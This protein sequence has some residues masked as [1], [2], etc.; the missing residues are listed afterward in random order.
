MK[1]LEKRFL[2]FL[3]M[4]LITHKNEITSI[5]DVKNMEQEFIKTFGT[6]ENHY[7]SYKK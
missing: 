7:K 6:E 3:S 2:E 4:Y 5:D 1:K